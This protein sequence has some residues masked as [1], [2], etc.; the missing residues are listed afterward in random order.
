MH[1]T[2]HTAAAISTSFPWQ[3]HGGHRSAGP[4]AGTVVGGGGSETAG[5]STPE[6]APEPQLA[7]RLP[8]PELWSSK[9]GQAAC[10]Q[11]AKH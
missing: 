9:E 10:G 2:F 4:T 8:G 3:H 1:Y 5:G 6:L 11:G 7:P